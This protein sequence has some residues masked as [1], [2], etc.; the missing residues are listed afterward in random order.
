MENVI[1]LDLC[2]K[3]MKSDRRKAMS[4]ISKSNYKQEEG[5]DERMKIVAKLN[6]WWGGWDYSDQQTG[7][8]NMK[9]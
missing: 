6:T 7:I 9:D 4:S 8:A 2:S 5:N 1:W 3:N